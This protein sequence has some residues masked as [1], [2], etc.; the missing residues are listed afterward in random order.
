MLLAACT[1]A[2]LWK[3]SVDTQ[4]FSTGLKLTQQWASAGTPKKGKH[5]STQNLVS[6]CSDTIHNSKGRN[7]P[8][9]HQL[10]R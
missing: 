6:E 8:N 7:N 1:G 10:K 2:V 4:Q 3:Q 5:M 9:V